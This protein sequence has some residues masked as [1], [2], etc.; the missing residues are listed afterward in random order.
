MLHD[1]SD[2]TSLHRLGSEVVAVGAP[3]AD[4]EEEGAGRDRAGVVGEIAHLD[5]RASKHLHRL[6]RCQ[7]ALQVHPSEC[8]CAR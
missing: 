2:R 4:G 7:E 8:T 3:A 1:E 5:R 6:E